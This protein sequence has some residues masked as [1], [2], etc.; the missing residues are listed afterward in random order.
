MADDLVQRAMRRDLSGMNLAGL[1]RMSFELDPKKTA[2]ADDEAAPDAKNRGPMTGRDIINRDEQVKD[3]RQLVEAM[4]GV[5]VHTYDEPDTSAWKRQRVIT[6]DGRVVYRVIRPVYEGALNDLRQQR[7]PNGQRL[8]GLIVYDIDRLTR[9]NRDLEDAIDV[10]TRFGRPII[11]YSGT[12]DLLTDNGRTVARIVV[13]TKAQ[14]SADTSRRVKRKHEAIQQ[15]GIPVGG[16]RPFGWLD[17]KRTLHP[18]ESKEL[19]KA[20]ARI[21]D[22]EN[23]ATLGEIVNDWNERGIR[24]TRGNEWQRNTLMAVLRNPRLCGYRM[25]QVH[26]FDNETGSENKQVEICYD[27][28]GHPVIGQWERV[29]TPEEREA[30]IEVLGAGPKRG[31]GHNARK[32]LLTG[33]I[34]C[35]KPGC[36]KPM[37]A[38]KATPSQRKPEGFFWYACKDKTDGGC[39]GT[40]IDG[41]AAD[42]WAQKLV[43]ARYEEDA[44]K[45]Q[46]T[47][48]PDE[49][50]NQA[51]LDQVRADIADLN[52]NKA[53]ISKARYWSMLAKYDA[54]EA[55]LTRERNK[56]L[57]KTAVQTNEPIDLQ[58]D[59]EAG[60]LSF[61]AQRRH[62]ENTLE[63]LICAPANGKRGV[64]ASDRLTPIW[65]N[66]D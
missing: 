28:E 51:E 13:A 60:R 30:L 62:V 11:D 40:K 46:A 26:N 8:D 58:A 19:K 6:P 45:R 2:H 59:W 47:H 65:R 25:R 10:V 43:I 42:K 52:A 41:P 34:R 55:K 44:A 49:W 24:T 64:K 38:V 17:D 4:G 48:L 18:T 50:D 53:S 39:A 3:C 31:D 33:T 36:G 7:D 9:D 56:Y 16:S 27:A 66:L 23:G 57:R 15:A 63:A 32:Y 37:R 35:G 20:I 29:I 12:L 22:P 21:L 5:Y 61:L 1:V 54:D 14:Q